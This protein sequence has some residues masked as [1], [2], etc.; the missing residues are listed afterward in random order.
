MP[1]TARFV[2]LFVIGVPLAFLVYVWTSAA[3]VPALQGTDASFVSVLDARSSAMEVPRTHVSMAQ[4]PVEGQQPA[5]GSS[6][7]QLPSVP[8]LLQYLLM[9]AGLRDASTQALIISLIGTALTAILLWRLFAQP[10][11]LV[12]PLAV[13]LDY[14]GFLTWTL[15]ASRIWMFVLFFALVLTV[16][17]NKPVWFGILAFCLIQVDYR[18]T[19]FVGVT[20]VTFALFMHKSNGLSFVAA[21]LLGAAMP[22]AIYC[23]EVL[24]FY[25][26]DDLLHEVGAGR[27][28][29][30]T[31]LSSR[32]GLKFLYHAGHGPFLL[33]QTVAQNTHSVAVLLTIVAGVIASLFATSRDWIDDRHKF[34]A[35]LTVSAA[36]GTIVASSTLYDAFVDGFAN[37]S[38]P[39]ASF[40]IAPSIGALAFE[41]RTLVGSFS[42]NQLVGA[43]ITGLVL[44]PLVLTS[45]IQMRPALKGELMNALPPGVRSGA[46]AVPKLDSWLSSPALAQTN[47]AD[48]HQRDATLASPQR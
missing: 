33:F 28:W 34:V 9:G 31:L 19:T 22:L 8:H 37:G 45:A 18:I 40:L 41:L 3:S 23:L 17:L 12:L 48:G 26:W 10:A 20:V 2:R 1:I 21:G 11:L 4:R 5:G 7:A 46:E 32:D 15:N 43:G 30:G 47:G 36:V 13:V 6:Y 35:K 42:K 29:L 16:R 38:L 39:L 44:L 14:A 27:A 24:R 25:G